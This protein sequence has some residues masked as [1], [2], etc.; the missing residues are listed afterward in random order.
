[1]EINQEKLRES[2]AL[3]RKYIDIAISLG[4]P[5]QDIQFMRLELAQCIWTM[6]ED[7][8]QAEQMVREVHDYTKMQREGEE[9]DEWL[10]VYAQA[11]DYLSEYAAESG[12][13][14]EMW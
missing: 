4:Q 12:R 1:M 14:D 13:F 8:P 11:L 3:Q 5:E 2:A 9:G 6:D 7:D 10:Q